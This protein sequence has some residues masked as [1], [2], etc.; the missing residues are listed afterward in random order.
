MEKSLSEGKI[1]TL[2]RF[3]DDVTE[4]KAGL[5]AVLGWILLMITKKVM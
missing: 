2:K 1:D 5:N 3:K 4:V